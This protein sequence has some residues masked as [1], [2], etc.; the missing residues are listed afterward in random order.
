[1]NITTRTS[2]VSNVQ[3]DDEYNTDFEWQIFTAL[4]KYASEVIQTTTEIIYVN[5]SLKVHE[6][7][8]SR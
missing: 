6:H 3:L 8:G 4:A 5:E 1:M 2:M 7:D